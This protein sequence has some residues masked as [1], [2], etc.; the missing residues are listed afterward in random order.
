MPCKA[1]EPEGKCQVLLQWLGKAFGRRGL[2]RGAIG[3]NRSEGGGW[4]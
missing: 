3:S 1:L 4:L 2:N